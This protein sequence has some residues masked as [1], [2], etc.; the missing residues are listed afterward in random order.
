MTPKTTHLSWPAIAAALLFT[1]LALAAG[2]AAVAWQALAAR[3]GEWSHRLRFTLAGRVV[4]HDVSMAT[5]LRLATHPLAARAVDGR[6]LHTAQGTW[7]LSTRGEHSDG[8]DGSSSAA[9]SERGDEGGRALIA[10]CEP[11]AF[12]LA[13][14][15][16]KP[17]RVEAAHLIVRA[18]GADRYRGTFTL[19]AAPRALTVAWQG[20]FDRRDPGRFRLDA[21]LPATPLAN[22]VQALG[23]DLPERD[24]VRVAGTLA[25]TA[26]AQWPR[27]PGRAW[28]IKPLIEGFEVHGLGTER[29][30]D[31]HRPSACRVDARAEVPTLDGW[32]PRAVVAAEDQRFHEHPGYDLAAM[33]DAWA[34]NQRPGAAL[35]GGSTI[36]QQTAKLL[37]AGDER[38]AARKLRELLY[39]VEM[40]RTLGKARILQLYLALAP[41]GEGV[42]GAERA[43]RVHLG[44]RDIAT[45]GP[46]AAAWLASLLPAPDAT[47]RAEREAGAVDEARVKRVLDAMRALRGERRDKALALLPFWAPPA[48]AGATRRVAAVQAVAA[49]PG[50]APEPALDDAAAPAAAAASTASTAAPPTLEAL[51]PSVHAP[52]AGS[53][54]TPSP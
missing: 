14:L 22:A 41:W 48:V 54:E 8:G 2:L 47:L 33:V 11:C 31:L 29:W 52:R 12:S 13:A 4:E 53:P 40:E 45:T 9:H 17:L 34:H 44:F 50:P 6:T 37:I 15:G 28:Q 51:S 18:E 3:E 16:P 25:F 49:P 30:A 21:T 39:A 26:S 24:T 1:L 20:R 36:S 43:V 19:G 38:S 46:L 27:E 10:R 32:L 42:C 35:A 5:L 7:Q 23:R